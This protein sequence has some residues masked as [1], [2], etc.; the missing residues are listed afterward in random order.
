MYINLYKETFFKKSKKIN[1]LKKKTF[2]N[3]FFKKKNVLYK[4]NNLRKKYF[5]KEL[6]IKNYDYKKIID[7]FL[8][9]FFTKISF[10]RIYN[11]KKKIF[12]KNR[13]VMVDTIHA[14]YIKSYNLYNKTLRYVY[15]KKNFFSTSLLWYR[16]RLPDIKKSKKQIKKDIQI[17]KYL[18]SSASERKIIELDI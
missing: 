5:F 18:K 4:K 10:I 16:F 9:K 11:V 14:K 17:E 15:L 12:L 7:F 13:K 1:I 2:N 8:K 6:K 3:F